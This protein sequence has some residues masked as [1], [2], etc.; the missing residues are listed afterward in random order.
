ML[1]NASIREIYPADRYHAPHDTLKAY[2]KSFGLMRADRDARE[3]I[4]Q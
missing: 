3:L 1:M 4:T 2:R